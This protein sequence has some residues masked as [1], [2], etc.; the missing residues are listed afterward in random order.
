MMT[1]LL[2]AGCNNEPSRQARSDLKP[3]EAAVS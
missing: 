3:A 1:L 2:I